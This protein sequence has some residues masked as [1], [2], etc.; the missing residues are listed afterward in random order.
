MNNLARVQEVELSTS[1][2]SRPGW[3]RAI[4][5]L[6]WVMV[7]LFSWKTFKYLSEKSYFLADDYDHFELAHRLP[8]LEQ[9]LTP[10]DVHFVPGHRLFS[11]LLERFAPLN[12]DVALWV[13]LGFHLLSVFMFSKVLG[14]LRSGPWNPL[15]VVLY[16]CG[17][18]VLYLLFWWSAGIHRLPYVLF[19]LCSIYGYLGY[20][21]HRYSRDLLVCV[22]GFVLAAAFYS[23]AVL[24]PGYLLALEL[25]LSWRMGLSGWRRYRL[26]VALL[27]LSVVYLG[28]YELYAPVLRFDYVLN[29]RLALDASLLGLDVFVRDLFLMPWQQEPKQL[30]GIWLG[31]VVMLVTCW[32]RPERCVFWLAL[33]AVLLV[34]LLILGVGNRV[35]TMGSSVMLALRYQFEPLFLLGLFLCLILNRAPAPTPRPRVSRYWAMLAIAFC[36]AYPVGSFLH[37]RATDRLMNEGGHE[38]VA[39][40]MSHLLAQLDGLPSDRVI[41]FAQ[42]DFP[43]QVYRVLFGPPKSFQAILP[44]RY[45]NLQFADRDK[46]QY[47]IDAR[48]NVL[49]LSVRPSSDDAR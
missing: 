3:E 22:G 43:A 36:V 46:A 18:S 27:L 21:Q 49:S 9:L 23:K 5:W 29:A 4:G 31:A 28:W 11:Y 42:G 34:N 47:E 12:F 39:D 6:S 20:R 7:L 13:M 15:L 2:E 37:A 19:C 25:C 33:L 24:L 14:R 38:Q 16:G 48:G 26:G 32:R 1:A 30:L 10:I 40:Y 44:L 45:P 35:Q 8:L 17:S 41:T